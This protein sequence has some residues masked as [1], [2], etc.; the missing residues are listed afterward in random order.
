MARRQ[1]PATSLAKMGMAHRTAAREAALSKALE[2]FAQ[3]PM[4][5][6]EMIAALGVNRSTGFAYLRKLRAD[7]KV[8][9]TEEMRGG[10]TLY[11]LGAEPSPDD[12]DEEVDAAMALKRFVAQASQVGMW[13][14]PLVAALFGPATTNNNNQGSTQCHAM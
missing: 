10:L 13:R 8:C 6:V 14:D 4:T 12:T 7:G 3:G 1:I 9:R 2:L 5:T 11:A